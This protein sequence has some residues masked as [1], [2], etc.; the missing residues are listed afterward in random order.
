M[1]THMTDTMSYHICGGTILDG[2]LGSP[3]AEHRYCDRCGAF[4]YG[5][6]DELPDGTDREA[7]RAAFEDGEDASPDAAVTIHCPV[8]GTSQGMHAATLCGITV[9]YFGTSDHAQVLRAWQRQ[10]RLGLDPEDGDCP[11]CAAAALERWA[12]VQS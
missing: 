8:P 7:N 10:V 12:G 2:G 11:D 1:M 9:H 6:D 5:S 4:R 3:E